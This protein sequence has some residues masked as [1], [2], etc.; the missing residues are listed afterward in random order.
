[1]TDSELEELAVKAGI[2]WVSEKTAYMHADTMRAFADA[3]VMAER[4]A[5]AIAVEAEALEFPTDSADDEAYD[6]TYNDAIRHAAAAIR[7]RSN[8]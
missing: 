4:E 3:L 7:V 6:N 5:C 2:Y 8:V 1:M